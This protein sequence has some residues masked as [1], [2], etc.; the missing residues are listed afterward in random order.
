[1]FLSYRAGD[2]E[3]RRHGVK[4][5]KE[6]FLIIFTPEKGHFEGGDS[7]GR[8]R[9]LVPKMGSNSADRLE[10]AWMAFG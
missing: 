5:R 8:N 2:Y 3:N 6:L 7:Q 9:I 1:V 10:P 4:P